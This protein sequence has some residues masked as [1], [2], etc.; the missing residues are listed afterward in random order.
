MTKL[1][2]DQDIY[3]S[4]FRFLSQSEHEVI[5]ASELGLSRAPDSQLLRTAHELNCIFITRDSDYGRLVFLHRFDAGVIYLRMR[6]ATQD[7]VHAELARVLNKYSFN[8]L[9]NAFVVV[10]QGGHRYRHLPASSA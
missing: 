5:R 3:L 7:D 9:R 1:L 2:L 6:P 10:E 8:E 4:T